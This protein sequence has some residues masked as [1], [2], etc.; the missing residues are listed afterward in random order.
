MQI[1]RKIFSLSNRAVFWLRSALCRI[2]VNRFYRF[3]FASAACG[4]RNVVITYPHCLNNGN[5][6]KK[7]KPI[8][9]VGQTCYNKN[10][11]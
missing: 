11:T 6:A 7:D 9:P 8:V 5:P 4:Y 2:Y 10:K 3:D 1:Y